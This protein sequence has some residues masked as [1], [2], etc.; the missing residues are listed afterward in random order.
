[1]FSDIV[2]LI[3]NSLIAS[4]VDILISHLYILVG[5]IYVDLFLHALFSYVNLSV[6]PSVNTVPSMITVAI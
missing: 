2:V 3:F 1:M 5:H 6:Y 4:D